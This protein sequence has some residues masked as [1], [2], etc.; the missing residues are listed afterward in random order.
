MGGSG[1]TVL[2]VPTYFQIGLIAYK[3]AAFDVAG[4][5]YPQPGWTWDDFLAACGPTDPAPGR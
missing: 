5:P 2:S 3:P 4:L 1:R